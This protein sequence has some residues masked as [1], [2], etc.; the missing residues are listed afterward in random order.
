MRSQ[1][2]SKYTETEKFD[3]EM[4]QEI[5]CFHE[6]FLRGSATVVV[7]PR[8]LI[9]SCDAIFLTSFK[10]QKWCLW[11][12]L[13]LRFTRSLSN[14]CSFVD[15]VFQSSEVICVWLIIS[16]QW[17][18]YDA[19]PTNR[20][21]QRLWI[22][23]FLGQTRTF[24]SRGQRIYSKFT[25]ASYGNKMRQTELKTSVSLPPSKQLLCEIYILNT[26]A[27]KRKHSQYD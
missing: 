3:L 13:V 19:C 14:A 17:F 9:Q 26:C 5:H 27:V 20:H 22:Q 18:V 7:F 15:R 1:L 8:D 23:N 24:P 11:G 2:D 10:Q 16:N 12:L 21:T 25:L 4:S 6:L